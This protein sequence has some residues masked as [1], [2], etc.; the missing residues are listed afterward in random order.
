M[1]LFESLTKQRCEDGSRAGGEHLLKGSNAITGW[2]GST[3]TI[4]C[5][6]WKHKNK[7]HFSPVPWRSRIQDLVLLNNQFP[8]I[9]Q[10]KCPVWHHRYRCLHVT[11]QHE[12][13]KCY[14]WLLTCLL[15]NLEVNEIC[16]EDT[17]PTPLSRR[18]YTFLKY[19]TNKFN[20]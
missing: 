4:H 2:R 7:H 16:H 18:Y 19:V 3:L 1:C 6:L 15:K 20:T 12:L 14:R 9:D 17:Y 11:L 8:A 13:A 10:Q 5:E